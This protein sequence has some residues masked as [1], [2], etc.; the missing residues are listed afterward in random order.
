MDAFVYAYAILSRLILHAIQRPSY[1]SLG[2]GSVVLRP[3]H[4]TNAHKIF[5]GANVT[6]RPGSRIECIRYYADELFDPLIE[7][8]DNTFVEYG[9]HLACASR[10]KI[11]KNVLLAANV[12]V[13]D[14]SHGFGSRD[15]HPLSTRIT[16]ADVSI[17]DGCWIGE[18]VCILPGTH[19]GEG[20]VVGAGA[21]VT[22]SFPAFSIV[23]GV[24]A[25]LIRE[26]G[27]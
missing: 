15:V 4:L 6:I 10:I 11:G 1:G 26:R 7:I 22:S 17:G 21:V 27:R 8:G 24:P 18:R 5:L 2:V 19:L 23:A 3:L 16:T 20:C 9:L 25:R 14:L 12:F 13:S